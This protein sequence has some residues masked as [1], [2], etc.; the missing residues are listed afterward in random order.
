MR[1]QEPFLRR[2][3]LVEER[4]HEGGQLRPLTIGQP[5]RREMDIAVLAPLIAHR[6]RAAGLKTERLLPP[7]RTHERNDLLGLRA[8]E[9]KTGEPRLPRLAIGVF[10]DPPVD[11]LG[12][13]IWGW[14]TSL[15]R[16]A[17]RARFD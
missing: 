10:G 14:L 3:L 2:P 1:A 7:A 13:R 12:A 8:R 4:E 11:E 15:R 5:V 6:G 17:A 16:G 9:G